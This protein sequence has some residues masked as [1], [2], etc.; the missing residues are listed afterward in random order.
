M[1]STISLVCNFRSLTSHRVNIDEIASVF[2]FKF[3][4][5]CRESIHIREEYPDMK[6]VDVNYSD[7]MADPEKVF[8]SSWS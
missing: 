4:K 7:L 2:P 1:A 6:F 8:P 5:A 3:A